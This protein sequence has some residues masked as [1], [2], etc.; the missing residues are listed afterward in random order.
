[1]RGGIFINPKKVI[2]SRWNVEVIDADGK[3]YIFNIEGGDGI[4]EDI[5]E[6]EK[7]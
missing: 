3:H 4:Q 2:L 6:G 5:E 1:M 7:K